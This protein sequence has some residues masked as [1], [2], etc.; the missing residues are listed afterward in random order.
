MKIDL[1]GRVA[2]VNKKPLTLIVQARRTNAVP[3]FQK[4]PQQSDYVHNW[5][6]ETKPSVGDRGP[7]LDRVRMGVISL[8]PPG[9]RLMLRRVIW[10]PIRGRFRHRHLSLSNRRHFRSTSM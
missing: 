3:I 7:L 10:E 5:A 1:S 4:T 2:L 8:I 6:R 9:A